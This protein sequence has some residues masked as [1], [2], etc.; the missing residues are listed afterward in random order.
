MSDTETLQ[1]FLKDN[2]PVVLLTGAGCSVGAGIPTYR[3]AEGQWQRSTPIQHQDFVSKHASRQRYW[4]RSFAGWP[5]V[6][7]AAPTNTHRA[8]A[9]LESAGVVSL[10]VTLN[11]DRLHQKAGSRKVVDLHGRLDEVVCLDCMHVMRRD[12]IQQQL[13]TL[14]P[15][16][17]AEAALA[18]DGDADVPDEMVDEVQIPSCPACGGMLKPNVVFF[19]GSV[20]KEVVQSVYT[21][22]EAAGALIIVGS[23]L[24]VFSGFRFLRHAANLGK[25]VLSVNPGNCRG[26]ELISVKLRVAA[27]EVLPAAAERIER[28]VV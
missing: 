4:L 3:D 7:A 12:D 17:R 15:F 18:P 2:A 23:S 13:F 19:G 9:Q 21:A 26:D 8:I 16:L 27:D 5:P 6:K 14:N 24:K 25:P 10:V 22:I 28:A 20:D 1:Q 11:V